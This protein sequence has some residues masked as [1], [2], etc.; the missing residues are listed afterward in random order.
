MN[1]LQVT[2]TVMATIES[3]RCR[4]LRNASWRGFEPKHWYS[5]LSMKVRAPR[6]SWKRRTLLPDRRP[7][8]ATAQHAGIYPG[9]ST[10]QVWSG[11]F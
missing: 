10:N 7:V 2:R 4:A 5:L 3:V 8:I 1:G 6:R 9:A 11:R